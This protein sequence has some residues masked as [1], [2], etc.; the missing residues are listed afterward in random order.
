MKNKILLIITIINAAIFLPF[1]GILKSFSVPFHYGINGNPDY[2]GN[3]WFL[4]V[5]PLMA[6]IFALCTY[7]YRKKLGQTPN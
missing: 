1:I 3:K 6:F 4:T 2:F 5:F 7:I